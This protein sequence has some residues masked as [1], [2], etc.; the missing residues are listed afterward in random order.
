[1]PLVVRAQFF[2]TPT[3]PGGRYLI[4]SAGDSTVTDGVLIKS[5]GNAFSLS[6]WV[7]LQE[8]SCSGPMLRSGDFKIVINEISG[9]KS[10]RASIKD[11]IVAESKSLGLSTSELIAPAQLNTHIVVTYNGSNSYDGFEIYI[12]GVQT[13]PDL[14]VNNALVS[15]FL[16]DSVV[17][18]NTICDYKYYNIQGYNYV[19][20]QTQVTTL[21]SSIT[22][23]IGTPSY[24]I[25]G[26]E[27]IKKS[28]FFD[29]MFKSWRMRDSDSTMLVSVPVWGEQQ[30]INNPSYEQQ[31]PFASVFI[32]P[33]ILYN[34]TDNCTYFSTTTRGGP[35]FARGG[36]ISRYNHS[37]KVFEIVS[38][39]NL[40]G[41]GKLLRDDH[42]TWVSAIGKDNSY[43]LAREETHNG[44]INFHKATFPLVEKGELSEVSNTP[45]VD[46]M[47]YPHIFYLGDTLYLTGRK[48]YDKQYIYRS[49]NDGETWSTFDT[50][51]A[52]DSGDWAYATVMP[53]KDSIVYHMT[54]MRAKDPGDSQQ[55][56]HLSLLKSTDGRMF[57]NMDGSRCEDISTGEWSFDELRKYAAIDSTIATGKS[58]LPICY[59]FEPNGDLHFG[60]VNGIVPATRRHYEYEADG[61]F[62]S[63]DTISTSWMYDWR[64]INRGENNWYI[65]GVQ[66]NG[67]TGYEEINVYSTTDW[68]TFTFE[69]TIFTATAVPGTPGI[70]RIAV[71]ANARYGDPIIVAATINLDLDREQ[72][73]MFIYEYNPNE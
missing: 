5:G 16:L 62:T 30:N 1:M 44:A 43:I 52:V 64:I 42:C 45:A 19:L 29:Q 55:W 11:S 15:G 28:G 72:T 36:Y 9:R 50:L 37:T 24:Y 53:Y 6:M 57:C 56:E 61:T 23:T 7:D 70:D 71:T 66:L 59:A 46:L 38:K 73:G 21:F 25:S 58:V 39:T 22:S 18:G 48:Q 20:N 34:P 35:G 26:T 27:K 13:S 32:S 47:A 17:L 8:Y 68:Q 60:T 65:V 10:V 40:D 63:Y 33:Y 12:N 69:Q 31:S 49:G 4:S 2:V 3:T 51:T 67:T 41:L 14:I 54:V